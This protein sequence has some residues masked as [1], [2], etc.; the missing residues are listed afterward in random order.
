M[1]VAVIPTTVVVGNAVA[2]DHGIARR[3]LDS[4]IG[5]IVNRVIHRENGIP[6]ESNSILD[7]RNTV[8]T[9]RRVH[10]LVG[11]DPVRCAGFRPVFRGPLFASIMSSLEF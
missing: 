6:H 11:E 9:D 5:E 7:I 2:T 3:E 10:D 4:V 1:M 8:F